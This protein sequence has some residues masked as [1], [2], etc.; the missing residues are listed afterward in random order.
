M[1]Q[2][3]FAAKNSSYSVV[4]IATIITLAIGIWL[5]AAHCF[6]K[7]II[8]AHNWL[9]KTG[10]MTTRSIN[11][12]KYLLTASADKPIIKANIDG[13]DVN[14]IMGDRLN[15]NYH[16]LTKTL[17]L[18]PVGDESIITD[19][20]NNKQ[21]LV[22][23]LKKDDKNDSKYSLRFS[24][25]IP[26]FALNSTDAAT[27]LSNTIKAIKSIRIHSKNSEIQIHGMGTISTAL[28]KFTTKPYIKMEKAGET[29]LHLRDRYVLNEFTYVPDK[30]THQPLNTMP[31]PKTTTVRSH[32]IIHLGDKSVAATDK[33]INEFMT[34]FN[35]KKLCEALEI[36]TKSEGKQ[37]FEGLIRNSLS[38]MNYSG[39]KKTANI[40]VDLDD[41]YSASW[42]QEYLP[43]LQLAASFINSEKKE[44]ISDENLLA[45]L[46]VIEHHNPIK[47]TIDLD[48]TFNDT[49]INTKLGFA[50]NI[51]Q[52]G[53]HLTLEIPF[54]KNEIWGMIKQLDTFTDREL[55]T[56]I[57][58]SITAKLILKNSK[59]IIDDIEAIFIRCQKMFNDPHLFGDLKTNRQF[60]DT[61]L[62][63]FGEKIDNNQL[64]IQISYDTKLKKLNYDSARNAGDIMTKLLPMIFGNGHDN[65]GHSHTH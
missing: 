50:Y 55:E 22:I 7:N 35:W 5:Y 54:K 3:T 43:L 34:S 51:E 10:H 56:Y 2:K 59:A 40:H 24:N 65:H 46:P 30:D 57:D 1:I 14:Y 39:S 64:K 52:H 61:A 26:T 12:N 42:K 28:F 18:Q 60:A 36:Q 32:T 41:L 23:L 8:Q 19:T 27:M 9:L 13:I 20:K 58:G 25:F 29:A 62:T 11:I 44:T 17:T 37:T 31:L 63:S 6:E 33:I 45:L 15:L 4:I 49:H 48:I 21:P 16:V 53:A 38:N 47:K